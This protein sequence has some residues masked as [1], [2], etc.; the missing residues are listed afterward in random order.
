M[1]LS[2]KAP[3]D[4]E[5]VATCRYDVGNGS[6][7]S[8]GFSAELTRD[9]VSL[10][11][12]GKL[13]ETLRPRIFAIGKWCAN[14]EAGEFCWVFDLSA[15]LKEHQIAET[16]SF[17]FAIFSTKKGGTCLSCRVPWP[18]HFWILQ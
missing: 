8:F 5:V 1:L 9:S 18:K 3:F 6:S 2:A 7:G 16:N 15:D 11:H 14:A 13:E 4:P 10:C 17:V 12:H